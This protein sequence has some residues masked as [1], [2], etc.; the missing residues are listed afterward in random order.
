M[1]NLEIKKFN[2][3]VLRKKC[4]EVKKITSEIKELVF[5]MGKIM[6]KNNGIGL[7]ASQ[8]GILKKIIVVQPDLESSKVVALINPKIIKKSSKREM[9]QEG[10]LSFPE[11]FLDIKR[12][13]KVEVEALDIDGYKM[14]IEAEGILARV[15]QHEIDHLNGVLF[16]DRLSFWKKIKFRIKNPSI[17]I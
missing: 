16:F 4:E 8:V 14:G 11:L 7:A 15:L 6:L 13:E 12:A 9:G 17:K 5:D 1:N 10:C 3:P 2:E